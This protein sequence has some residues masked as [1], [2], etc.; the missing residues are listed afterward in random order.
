[1]DYARLQQPHR[2]RDSVRETPTG[3]AHRVARDRV[4]VQSGLKHLGTRFSYLEV[5]NNARVNP[6]PVSSDFVT[7]EPKILYFGNPV[8]LISSLNQDGS[9]NLA[10]MS[11]F[12]ALGWTVTLGLLTETQTLKNLKL[13]PDCVV[14]LPS[15]DMWKRVE[16]LAP[17]TGQNPVP[18]KKA[19]QFRYEP[20]KFAAAEFS[21]LASDTVAAPRVLECPVQLEARVRSI[22]ELHGDPRLRQLGG[23][24][25]VEVEVQR[26]H[27]RKDFVTRGH[28]IA[29]DKWQPLIYNF[30]HYF[31]LGQEL[32]K[33]FRAEV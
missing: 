2:S 14:N 19:S 29:P 18:Q 8:A 16:R 1:L 26:V 12:W 5:M 25:S 32:G 13:C 7:I 23:G 21:T 30:R 33:T 3:K 28:Y 31:G 17:L 4:T 20:D 11:S 22:H 10:P 27:A 6:D 15:P 9:P 24:A